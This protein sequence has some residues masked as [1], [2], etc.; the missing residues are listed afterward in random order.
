LGRIS[1]CDSVT[2]ALATRLSGRDDAGMALDD[3]ERHTSLITRVDDGRESYRLHPLLRTYLHADLNRRHPDQVSALHSVAARWFTGENRIDEALSH[4]A[5]G[6]NRAE[7]VDL[8]HAKAIPM[9]LGGDQEAVRDALSYLDEETIH[10]DPHLMLVS[11]LDHV[12]S[13]QLIAS[14]ADLDRWAAHEGGG[15]GQ[16]LLGWLMVRHHALAAGKRP[17]RTAAPAGARSPALGAWAELDR[18]WSCLHR[19]AR[20]YAAAKAT[21]ALHTARHHSL[22]YLVMHGLRALATAKCLDGDHAAMRA[23][24]AEAVTIGRRRGWRRS[25]WLADCHLMLAYDH[26]LQADPAAAIRE[27]AQAGET[28]VPGATPLLEPIEKFLYGV[29]RF[30]SGDWLAGSQGMRLARLLV[31]YLDLPRELAAALAAF[32]HRAALSLGETLHAREVQ[33]WARDR[34][35]GTAELSLLKTW[36][37][38]AAEQTDLAA[39]AL[40]DMQDGSHR[41]L[42]PTTPVDAGLVGTALGLRAGRRTTALQA[43][44]RA[45]ALAEPTGVIRSFAH[46]EPQVRHLL[47]EQSGGFGALDDFARSVRGRIATRRQRAIADG[48]TERERVVLQ[49]LPSPRSLDEIALD[50]TVSVNTVKTHVRGIYSKLGV[51]NRRSAV[52]V[53]REYGIA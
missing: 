46:A 4:A 20:R 8:L 39:A 25:P 49:R 48:L 15:E 37:Y 26:L 28:I 34:L 18:A 43:L 12:Q 16:R 9:L 17:V 51:N 50:L 14:A 30:D 35:S 19:G 21:A 47:I 3:L 52:V 11:A 10:H 7:L 31:A 5:A 1:V 45:L 2:A 13:G 6:Q 32:E 44:D 22:D 33:S 40:R 29:A 23:A 42:L 24:C 41:V 27:L 38:L 53:A 36:A